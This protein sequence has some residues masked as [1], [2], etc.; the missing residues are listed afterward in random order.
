MKRFILI[1]LL[2]CAFVLGARVDTVAAPDRDVGYEQ[3]EK[4]IFE[5]AEF[6]AD[7]TATQVPGMENHTPIYT[8]TE[9]MPVKVHAEYRFIPWGLR[10]LCSH[11][12][13]ILTKVEHNFGKNL[14]TP[15]VPICYNCATGY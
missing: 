1:A 2:G 5:K 10:S 11:N 3:I 4:A 12:T 13:Y 9:R 7:F 15:E 8:R 6:T 14:Y